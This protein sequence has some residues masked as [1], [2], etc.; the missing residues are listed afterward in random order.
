MHRRIAIPG[1][2]ALL[3]AV[4]AFNVQVARANDDARDAQ[5]RV[6]AAVHVVHEMKQ[7]PHLAS[8]LDRARGVYIIP[9]YG[10]GAF[11][12]GGHGG[13]G[14]VLVKHDGRWSDPAFYNIGGASVGFQA[15]ATGGSVAMLLMTDNAVRHFMDTDHRW[16]LSGGAGLTIA[17]YNG[18][19]YARA[20]NLQDVIIW[21]NVRGLY[22]GLTAGVTHI[23]PDKHM[24]RAYYDQKT[25]SHE[26]LTGQVSNHHANGLRDAL[27]T[28]VASK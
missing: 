12:V 13:V 18:S 10:S 16:T 21:S 17:K 7:D 22:G 1:A 6:D 15:G 27:G 24:D 9:R 3:A 20:G 5:Q 4:F 11:I 23:A 8:L 26:I 19:Q 28:Q 25:D 14:V 2:I